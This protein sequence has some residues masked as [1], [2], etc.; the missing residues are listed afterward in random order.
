MLCSGYSSLCLA[1]ALFPQT[2]LALYVSAF[3]YN[4]MPKITFPGSSTRKNSICS[5]P[6]SSQLP[7]TSLSPFSSALPLLSRTVSVTGLS[8]QIHNQLLWAGPLLALFVYLCCHQCP[9]HG[10]HSTSLLKE[11]ILLDFQRNGTIPKSWNWEQSIHFT[12]QPL[13]KVT[14]ASIYFTEALILSPG[15]MHNTDT[16]MLTTWHPSVVTYFAREM[17]LCISIRE[18]HS[19]KCL[20]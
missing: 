4:T 13:N 5:I 17:L 16:A 8:S 10:S 20:L 3:L 9:A 2:G 19:W 12:R 15:L 1:R 18:R 7:D 14:L 11:Y 6:S